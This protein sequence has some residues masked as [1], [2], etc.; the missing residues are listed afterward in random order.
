[1]GLMIL[2][3]LLACNL[4][5]LVVV[6]NKLTVPKTQQSAEERQVK[7]EAVEATPTKEVEEHPNNDIVGK[8]K[9]DIEEWRKMLREEIKEVVPLVIKEY[10]SFTDAGWPEYTD[11]DSSAAEKVVA[12]EK[13]DDVFTNKTVSELTGTSPEVAEPM[14]GGIR[15]DEMN[16]AMKVLNGKSD[17]LNDIAVTRTVLEE[18]S[19]T[20]FFQVIRLDPVIQKR[21]LQIE[22]ELPE[23]D[24]KSEGAVESDEVAPTTKPKKIVYKADINTEGFDSVNLN[25]YH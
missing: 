10:G 14:A 6:W 25:I 9:L 21:M 3:A 15:F 17:A 5:L 16:T 12:S 18:V 20:E 1:M 19:D 7:D 4:L 24:S 13:L 8:S 11:K 23:V 22:C 2:I